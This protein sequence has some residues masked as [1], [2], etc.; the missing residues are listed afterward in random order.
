MQFPSWLLVVGLVAQSGHRDSPT[1]DAR[2]RPSQKCLA[3]KSPS[4]IV[5]ETANT[6][7]MLIRFCVAIDIVDDAWA[8]G[9]LV[10]DFLRLVFCDV[11]FA[12]I[13]SPEMAGQ[14]RLGPDPDAFPVEVCPRSAATI[15]CSR[16]RKLNGSGK[17]KLT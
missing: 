5:P 3:A 9:G 15:A 14:A 13:R 4:R 10:L 11:V 17:P 16:T 12:A 2:C 1:S 6:T 8:G 7:V